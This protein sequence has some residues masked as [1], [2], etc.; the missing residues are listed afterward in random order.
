MAANGRQTRFVNEVCA[1]GVL[2]ILVSISVTLLAVA[3][4]SERPLPEL[5]QTAA[6]ETGGMSWQGIAIVLGAAVVTGGATFVAQ[7]A[8]ERRKAKRYNCRLTCIVKM[9]GDNLSARLVNISEHGAQIQTKGYRLI[10]GDRLRLTVGAVVTDAIVVWSD[11][12][13]AGMRFQYALGYND[14]RAVL[15]QARLKGSLMPDGAD[16]RGGNEDTA[17]KQSDSSSDRS[18]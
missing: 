8:R 10:A 11:T 4:R 9:A 13:R 16:E 7:I 14:F 5:I 3:R 12:G 2:I 1:F 17:D 6:P 15:R 18:R